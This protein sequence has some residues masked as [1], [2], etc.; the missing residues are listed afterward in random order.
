MKNTK[1]IVIILSIFAVLISA[2]ILDDEIQS[3]YSDEDGFTGFL[4]G[5]RFYFMNSL[6]VAIVVYSLIRLITKRIFGY[7]FPLIL[8]L[9][10]FG[11]VITIR[12]KLAARE[13]SPIALQAHY[14]GD[15]N[16]LTLYLKE[17]KTYKLGNYGIFGGRN[18]YGDYRFSGDTILL[19]EKYPLGKD[20]DIMCNKLL[21][22]NGFILVKPDSTGV[23]KDN[24]PFQLRIIQ[25]NR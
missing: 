14:D 13:S 23:Y 11:F 8:C 7:L 24:S 1:T 10:H 15:I 16:G 19:S 2:F 18:H 17:N 9:I 21:I 22:R 25:N 20:N 12:A 5:I 6:L 3:I 4:L